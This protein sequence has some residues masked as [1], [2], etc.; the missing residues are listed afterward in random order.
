MLDPVVSQALV[1]SALPPHVPP[2]EF[3]R[4]TP[5][6]LEVL[7]LLA[8]GMSNRAIAD[9]LFLGDATVKTHVAR[10]LTKLG[11]QTRAEAIIAA[12]DLGLVRPRTTE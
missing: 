9:H 6:E 12:Y 5:R 1:A 11:L 3:D 10:V 4:L 8:Q 2:V 7:G